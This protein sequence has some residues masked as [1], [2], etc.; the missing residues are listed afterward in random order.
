[1]VIHNCSEC[2]YK[3]IR[4]HHVKRHM[5]N[6]HDINVTWNIC[7]QDNCEYKTKR[8]ENLKRHKA[9]IHDIDAVWHECDQKNCKYKTKSPSSLRTHKENIHDIDITWHKCD[10]DNCDFK[11]KQNPDLTMHKA[12]VH[13]IGTKWKY[14][15][16]ENCDFKCKKFNNLSQHKASIH[17]MD[18][19]WNECDM[20]DMKFKAKS[21]LK[22]HKE[23][24]HDIGEH[25]CEFCLKNRN[26]LTPYKDKQGY[27][28][29]CRT[30][31]RKTT[32]KESR[33]EKIWSEY[34]DKKYGTEFLK[35]SDNRVMG[36]SC[37]QYRPDKLYASPGLVIHK[38]CD[39]H[40]HK[41]MN[42]DY[43]CDEKRISNIYDE[44]PGNKYIVTR[45]NPH[46]YK[47]EKREKLNRKQRL[48]LDMYVTKK[49]SKVYKKL[50]QVFII[51][52][53]YDTDNPRLT[54]NIPYIIVNN[55]QEFKE[56][57]KSFENGRGEFT[58]P[59]SE[60]PIDV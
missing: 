31:Y 15:D 14:C 16:Q 9:E 34:L 13:Y 4:K 60:K 42:G 29:I 6:I 57:L 11:S 52:M 5:E 26:S 19:T 3:S 23:G 38:E 32:G 7:D 20:C 21:H 43:A 45:W 59:K 48:K 33:I 35:V 47:V 37:Q 55:K 12:Q 46:T 10:Q 24:V 27:H 54:K 2:D 36:E 22:Q 17:D 44:F 28:K 40:Q 18:I 49:I 53:F 56:F 30:C 50:P 1:M 58:R 39:E 8:A 51:Y 25:E 41:R